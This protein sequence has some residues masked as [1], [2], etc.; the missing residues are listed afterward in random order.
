VKSPDE[1]PLP[2]LD[3]ELK[4]AIDD[5]KRRYRVERE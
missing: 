3:S 5:M 2:E 1:R 4:A